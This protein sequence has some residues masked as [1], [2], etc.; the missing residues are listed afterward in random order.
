MASGV[1]QEVPG[2][3]ELVRMIATWAFFLS[4]WVDR[5]QYLAP[6]KAR[7]RP[8]QIEASLFDLEE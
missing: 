4:M 1:G 6:K 7:G 3:D 5:R 8:T 2:D